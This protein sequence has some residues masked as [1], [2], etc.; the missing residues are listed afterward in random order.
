MTE[1]EPLLQS[2]EEAAEIAMLDRYYGPWDPFDPTAA[3]AFLDGF[4]RPWWIVGGWSIEAFTGVPR[5]HEDVDVS[6]LACD[7]PALREHVGDRYQLWN[8]F[9]GAFRPLLDRWV[10]QVEPDSQ[11]WVRR[12]LGSPWLLDIVLTPDRDGLWTNKRDPDHVVPVEEATWL[13]DD[14]LRYQRP[15]IT[16]LFKAK[17]TRLKDDR[18]LAVTWP[19][20]PAD[21]QAW[22]RDAVARLH[23]D[24]PWL[25]G[26]LA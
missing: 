20:L 1:R 13:A 10:D 6:L 17:Q 16:L 4:S 23:P 11:I 2:V 9:R 3:A 26:L 5:E 24:H 22:L 21:R 25:A 19:L 18:D 12:E 15:E 7:V 8:V 14:G